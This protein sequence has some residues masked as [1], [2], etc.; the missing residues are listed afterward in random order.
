MFVCQESRCAKLCGVKEGKRRDGERLSSLAG[1]CGGS[2]WGQCCLRRGL[3]WLWQPW[4]WQSLSEAWVLPAI[5]TL[6]SRW[7]ECYSKVRVRR[8][9]REGEKQRGRA[10]EVE[11]RGRKREDRE[12]VY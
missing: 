12:G 5:L 2:G 11:P 7:R 6:T 1:V 4:S 3:P 8:G 9:G 10:R